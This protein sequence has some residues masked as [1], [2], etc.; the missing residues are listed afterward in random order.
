MNIILFE[1]NI[2]LKSGFSNDLV[3][4]FKDVDTASI[5]L[6][7]EDGDNL[8]RVNFEYETGM[9]YSI[10]ETEP[11]RKV[12][13]PLKNFMTFIISPEIAKPPIS[14]SLVKSFYSVF[15]RKGLFLCFRIYFQ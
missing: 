2:V 8:V 11:N 14:D 6:F 15:K 3:E 5:S 10:I 12:E 4:F 7:L 1:G 13:I 9:L